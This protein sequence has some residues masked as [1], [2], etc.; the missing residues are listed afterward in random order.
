MPQVP[1]AFQPPLPLTRPLTSLPSLRQMPSPR[2]SFPQALQIQPPPASGKGSSLQSG[3]V[4]VRQHVNPLA[5]RWSQPLTLP[6]DWYSL[7]FDDPGLPL[8]LDL[9]TAKGRFLLR[10]ARRHP[11]RNF[12]GLEIREPLVHQAN[13]VAAEQGLTNLWYLAC[14]ANVSLGDVLAG[15]PS[16]IL[17][18]VYVQ[19]CDP[20]FKKRHAKRR[21]VNEGL[22]EAIH[23]GL[24][25]GGGRVF[26]Q[27]DV[28]EVA[29]EMRNTFEV[30]GGFRNVEEA[31][32]GCNG[33]LRE[34]PLE[35]RTERE[36]AVMNKGGAVM[37]AMF[38]VQG[39]D[40]TKVSDTN[41]AQV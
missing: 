32:I 19:F 41:D 21:M 14:N 24:K 16:G 12:L 18:D 9:G 8:S 11:T 27:S 30:H 26:V 20:W 34:N 4:R 2:R 22:V 17:K 25:V 15:V 3:Q 7:A 29:V 38:L 40:T 5:R 33:W 10:M 1:P 23:G 36:I 35:E 31:S 13:R 28:E 6:P 39:E 37:R